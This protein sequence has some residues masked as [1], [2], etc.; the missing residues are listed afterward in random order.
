MLSIERG[1]VSAQ[2]SKL[3]QLR[4]SQLGMLRALSENLGKLGSALRLRLRHN[5]VDR[6]TALAR[7]ACIQAL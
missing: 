4:L 6:G 3:T 5:I 7:Q 2:R 1:D